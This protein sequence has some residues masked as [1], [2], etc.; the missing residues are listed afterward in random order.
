MSLN[1]RINLENY[2]H[3]IKSRTWIRMGKFHHENP[4]IDNL[5]EIRLDPVHIATVVYYSWH[6]HI[7]ATMQQAILV[8]PIAHAHECL[9]VIKIENI[10]KN[11]ALKDKGI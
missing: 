4:T 2:V 8:C 6:E 9:L 10:E 11:D 7:Q 1:P 3:L 5:I